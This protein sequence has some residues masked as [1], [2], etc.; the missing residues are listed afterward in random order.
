[1]LP[2]LLLL[3]IAVVAVW[4]AFKFFSRPRKTPSTPAIESTEKCPRCGVYVP[5]VN[6]T[7]CG[8]E[9]CPYPPL[10]KPGSP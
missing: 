3:A 9:A 1:M 7:A 2:K 10:G 6:A 5:T 8:R 4:Y